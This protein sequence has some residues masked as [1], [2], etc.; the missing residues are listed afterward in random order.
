LFSEEDEP[1]ELQVIT[2]GLFGRK[3]TLNFV[4]VNDGFAVIPTGKWIEDIKIFPVVS[5]NGKIYEA[6]FKD[7]YLFKEVF[8]R[9]YGMEHYLKYFS[10]AE[11]AVLFKPY[12]GD[13][14]YSYDA[15]GRYFDHISQHYIK[16]IQENKVQT[17]M[18][19][20]VI[21]LL[22]KTISD[23]NTVLDL[24][25]GPNSEILQIDKNISV[26][27]VDVSNKMIEISKKNNVN[28][29]MNVKYLLMRSI[30][31]I[32][33]Q[34]DI[35]FSTFGFLNIE[36]IKNIRKI[37]NE[38]L[39]KGGY[40]IG[41]Y[42]NKF[43]LTDVLL[44]LL[45]GKFEYIRERI[46]GKLSA[47]FSRYGILSFP[48][49][50]G[51]LREIGLDSIILKNGMCII[52]PPYNYIRL[53]RWIEKF[54]LIYQLDRILSQLPLVSEYSDFIMFIGKKGYNCL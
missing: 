4:T 48:R 13:G 53:N 28:P 8:I 26:T 54:P 12:S 51:F 27:E 37:I 17:L 5:I 1:G 46:S 19:Q 52:L 41:T 36:S 15:I 49:G 40:F 44:S 20:T 35:I 14:D 43:C 7:L 3:I 10:G 21:E 50:P 25:S 30:D 32:E 31:D 11:E 24:G 45:M 23:G 2:G 29:K 39:K 38:H 22:S 6:E 18:R 47:N 33:G 42:M 16:G 34:Y 9:K